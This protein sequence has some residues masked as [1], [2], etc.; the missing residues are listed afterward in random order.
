MPGARQVDDG[1]DGARHR[2][3]LRGDG[4]AL[5]ESVVATETGVATG[6]NTSMRTIG[7]S[8]G[9]QVAASI[10]TGSLIAGTTFRRRPGTPRRSQS[11]RPCSRSRRSWPAH[12]AFR[13]RARRRRPRFRRTWCRRRHERAVARLRR[14]P[15]AG[16][17]L[18]A[19]GRDSPSF[20]CAAETNRTGRR[21]CKRGT[22]RRRGTCRPRSS[23]PEST[24]PGSNA[25]YRPPHLGG[26]WSWAAGPPR[27]R[28]RLSCRAW[29]RPR[30][31]PARHEHTRDWS[32]RR[33]LTVSAA[34][35]VV[36]TNALGR[37]GPGACLVCSSKD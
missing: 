13:P 14:P 33:A 18:P 25:R 21:Q 1:G 24:G 12:P 5:V 27:P 34:T 29:G 4:N 37:L 28:P 2:L 23:L 3:R 15:G 17:G 20:R 6:V 11:R 26:Q 35:T 9:A 32:E 22:R 7:G 16:Q 10:V 30:G 19:R 31:V 36:V 8:I